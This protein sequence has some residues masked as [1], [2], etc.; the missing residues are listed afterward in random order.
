MQNSMT[1]LQGEDGIRIIAFFWSSLRVTKVVAGSLMLVSWFLGAFHFIYGVDWGGC[2][3]TEEEGELGG[4]V[5]A[6]GF[7]S[8]GN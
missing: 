6:E 8:I 7:F 1:H 5:L 4:R 2:W 3:A